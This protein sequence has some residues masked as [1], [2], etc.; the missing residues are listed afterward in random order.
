MGLHPGDSWSWRV[1]THRHAIARGCSAHAA[2][3]VEMMNWRPVLSADDRPLVLVGLGLVVATPLVLV[4]L[5][6]R[7]PTGPGSALV[8]AL[9]LLLGSIPALAALAKLEQDRRLLSFLVVALAAK[10]AGAFGRFYLT[11]AAYGG[12]ADAVLYDAA[13]REWVSEFKS[14]RLVWVAENIDN[15]G[16]GTKAMGTLTGLVY[17]AAGRNVLTGFVVFSWLGFWGL[18]MAYRAFVIAVPDGDRRRYRLLLFFLPSLVFWPSSIGKDAWMQLTL[19][20]VF[21]GVAM[22][23]RHHPRWSGILWLVAGLGGAALLR[24]HIALAALAP[25][26]VALAVR[27]RSAGDAPKQRKGGV[28]R[29]AGLA[30]LGVASLVLLNRVGTVFG[31]EADPAAGSVTGVLDTA[32]TITS[33]GGSEFDAATVTG[34]T[35][36]PMATISVLFRPFLWEATSPVKAIAGIETTLLLVL[37]LAS[38]RR[39]RAL[40][41]QMRRNRYLVYVAVFAVV[42]IVGFSRVGNEGILARQRTQFLPAVLVLLCIPVEPRRTDGSTGRDRRSVSPGSLASVSARGTPMTDSTID[43]STSAPAPP[44]SVGPS[45]S[46]TRPNPATRQIGRAVD[47]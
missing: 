43:T 13:G 1:P 38:W 44:D 19:G 28:V 9:V 32:S 40:P 6:G 42:S 45:R 24:P 31:N 36:L 22:L 7:A 39:L 35:D 11:N 8:V 23:T 14:G 33:Q 5:D 3:S 41:G 25:L 16:A 30:I 20:A 2:G 10:L 26:A 46:T 18:V 21:L 12:L 29:I 34:V 17:A 37:T 27:Q 4:L 15:F 47:P